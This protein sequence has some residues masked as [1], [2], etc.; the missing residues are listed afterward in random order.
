MV[1]QN[2]AAQRRLRKFAISSMRDF[3]VGRKSL[4]VR[5][6]DEA[7]HLAAEIGNLNE[8][9]FDPERMLTKAVSNV[10]SSIVFGER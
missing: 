6:Q 7:G 4:E 10:I 2:G 1:Y 8:E 9:P 3:G 5:I